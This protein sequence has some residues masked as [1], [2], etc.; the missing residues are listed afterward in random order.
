MSRNAVLCT[1][2]KSGLPSWE[3][4]LR[5]LKTSEIE[6]P[7]HAAVLLPGKHRNEFKL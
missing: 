5:F 4:A 3:R 6:L 1:A 2:Q 7:Y